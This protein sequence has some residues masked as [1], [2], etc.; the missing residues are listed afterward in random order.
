MPKCN[1]EKFHHDNM[2]LGACKN[3]SNPREAI[4]L[5]LTV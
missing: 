2:F 5:Y 1:M 4:P 3:Y